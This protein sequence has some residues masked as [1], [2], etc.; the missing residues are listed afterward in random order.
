MGYQ[1]RGVKS[2]RPHAEE[3]LPE[4][5]KSLLRQRAVGK[6]RIE[7]KKTREVF[8]Q[9]AKTGRLQPPEVIP[10]KKPAQASRIDRQPRAQNNE[11]AG[12]LYQSRV[13]LRHR[14]PLV[15]AA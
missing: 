2:R 4:P 5:E 3:L 11:Q 14:D 13:P 15:E 7:L 9:A 8:R 10:D 6:S 1:A 12:Q